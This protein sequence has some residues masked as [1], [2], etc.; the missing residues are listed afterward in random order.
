M[1]LL[2][3]FDESFPLRFALTLLHF[4]WQ[5]CAV[6]LLVV[7]AGWMLR[8]ASA[9]WR[10][11]I[12]LA[13]MLMMVTCL[14]VTFALVDVSHVGRVS[15]PDTDGFGEP[16]YEALTSDPTSRMHPLVPPMEINEANVL[17]DGSRCKPATRAIS[18][19]FE[20]SKLNSHEPINENEAGPG[21]TLA[22]IAPVAPYLTAIY[23]LG[24]AAMMLRLAGGLWG[25][26]RLRRLATPVDEESLLDMVRRQARRI[27]LKTA[28]AIAYCEQVSIP[29]LIGIIK[30][31]ILLPAALASGLSPDQLQTLVMHELAHIRRYDLLVNLLQRLIEAVLF[32]HPGVWYV[33]RRVSMER[34]HVADDAVVAAGWQ[35]VTYADALVRMAELSSALRN[36]GI[37]SRAT[38]LAATGGASAS[39]FKRRVLRVLENTERPRLR[40]DGGGLLFMVLVAGLLLVT[41]AIIQTWAAKHAAPGPGVLNRV[42]EENGGEETGRRRKLG[43]DRQ[44]KADEPPPVS[45][46]VRAKWGKASSGLRCRMVTVSAEMS[47]DEIDFSQTTVRFE[48]ADQVAFAVEVQN[49]SDRPIRLLDTRARRIYP[50]GEAKV[51]PSADW[52]GPF[53]FSIDFFDNDGRKIRQPKVDV[54]HL[55]PYPLNQA[56]ETT[57]EPGKT[58]RFLLRP[59][60]WLSVMTQRLGTGKYQAA[61]HYHGIPARAVQYLRE[62]GR[63][64]SLLHVWSGDVVSAA[65]AF[66]VLPPD[67]GLPPHHTSLVW[68]EESNGLR[69]ALELLPGKDAYTHGEIVN[70]KLH[71]RN[72]SDSEVSFRT[73]L[74]LTAGWMTVAEGGDNAVKIR[75]AGGCLGETPFGYVTLLPHQTIILDAGQLGFAAPQKENGKFKH[76]AA[77]TMVAPAGKHKLRFGHR[78]MDK[79]DGAWTIEELTSGITP[80]VIAAKEAAHSASPTSKTEDRVSSDSKP[81]RSS[82]CATIVDPEGQPIADAQVEFMAIE[83][84]PGAHNGPNHMVTLA[85]QTATTDRYGAAGVSLPLASGWDGFLD[86]RASAAGT[87]R[88]HRQYWEPSE[89]PRVVLWPATPL[90]GR[91]VDGRGEPVAGAIVYGHG[92]LPQTKGAEHPRHRKWTDYAKTN[93]TGHFILARPADVEVTL[94]VCSYAGVPLELSV[95]ADTDAVG[96]LRLSP[97]TMVTGIVLDE[98]GKPAADILVELS[99]VDSGHDAAASGAAVLTDRNGHFRLPPRR[100]QLILSLGG[101]AIPSQRPENATI[102]TARHLPYAPELLDLSGHGKETVRTI[103][104]A[105]GITI[106]GQ[107]TDSGG[108]P[109]PGRAKSRRGWYGRVVRAWWRGHD[110]GNRTVWLDR[111]RIDNEG[112]YELRV[113]SNTDAIVLWAGVAGYPGHDSRAVPMAVRDDPMIEFGDDEVTL[114]SL[115][116]DIELDWRLAPVERP[117]KTGNRGSQTNEVSTGDNSPPDFRDSKAYAELEPKQRLK[118]ETVGRDLAVLEAALN[119]YMKDHEGASPMTLDALVPRYIAELPKDP[120]ATEETAADENLGEYSPSLDGWG[121][122]YRMRHRMAYAISSVDPLE[123]KSLPGSWE[124]RSVGLPNFPYGYESRNARGLYQRKGYW[125]RLVFDVF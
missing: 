39:D 88:H 102:R 1:D 22:W 85:Q 4:L 76:L 90:V 18:H 55:A 63:N 7:I 52:L 46:V 15:R 38:A 36:A 120:F 93:D 61:V 121:Y 37:A 11:L 26:L 86:I 51:E 28:P 53:L 122:R 123:V 92:L 66:E 124:V 125:G 34:E 30:P 79:K 21:R 97:G 31:T 106:R 81:E 62:K 40:L 80:V 82:Y 84:Q 91:V 100:G 3:W 24:V 116:R 25:G 64:S 45:S 87:I 69:A 115:D 10:Y 60:K 33:S 9:E 73:D 107:I 94:R 6:M 114:R 110:A 78:F 98:D 23:F 43:S 111:C 27:G 47:E 57:L 101:V 71:V 72:V 2:T 113:A 54:Q 56:L 117:G 68:G 58:H 104:A 49:A 29:V 89:H 70:G 77:H 35:R 16:S 65:S 95:G 42:A 112:R 50:G 14:P 103:R 96:D 119:R 12:N 74:W 19:S 20:I 17:A 13:A 108:R 118:L 109:V 59:A 32:F 105:P 99:V 44:P 8:R 67:H 48:R 41:T 5:G 83:K 75:S